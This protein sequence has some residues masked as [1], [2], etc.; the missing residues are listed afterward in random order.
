M[1]KADQNMSSKPAPKATPPK[2]VPA[3]P[4]PAKPAF[5]PP[6]TVKAGDTLSKIAKKYY[7]DESLYTKIY[8]ANKDQIGSSP[9][10]IKVGMI[11][12]IPSK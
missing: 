4:I 11:L 1:E 6:Y 10:K 9:D 7:G 3:S 12:K 8:E 5:M 2:P